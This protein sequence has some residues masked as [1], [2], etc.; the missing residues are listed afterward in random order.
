MRLSTLFPL[1]MMAMRLQRNDFG[2]C[3]AMRPDCQRHGDVISGEDV[4]GGA[5]IHWPHE[6]PYR[7]SNALV[8]HACTGIPVDC[9]QPVQMTVTNV[10]HRE[11][12]HGWR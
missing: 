11:R 7:I 5:P 12:I 6:L 3:A 8:M 4:D 10:G 9:N 2:T 1:A